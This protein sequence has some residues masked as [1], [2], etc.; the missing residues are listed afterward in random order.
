M[1]KALNKFDNNLCFTVDMFQNEVPHFLD[2]E[3][4]PD[5]FTIFRKDTKTGLYINFTSFMLWTYCTSWIT[6]FVTRASRICSTDKLPTEINTIKRFASW[7]N[8][9]KPVVNK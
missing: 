9:P 4:S 2:L 7:N 3:L 5:G 1:H 6:R 8:F